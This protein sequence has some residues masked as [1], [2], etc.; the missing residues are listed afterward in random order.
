MARGIHLAFD[1]RKQY[2][3]QYYDEATSVGYETKVQEANWELYKKKKQA[4][5]FLYEKTQEAEAQK[6]IAAT[7][8]YA[9]QQERGYLGT[10]PSPVI[11]GKTFFGLGKGGSKGFYSVFAV[12][13]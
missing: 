5:A 10:A 3:N 1:S 7:A 4:E 12:P 13:K 11:S 8:F 9:K 2:Q 6:A